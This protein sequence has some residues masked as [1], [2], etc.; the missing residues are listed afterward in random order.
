MVKRSLVKLAEKGL[1]D[2]FLKIVKRLIALEIFDSP[3]MTFGPAVS[4]KF[5][6]VVTKSALV[7]R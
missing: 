5:L 6:N 7:V 3:E 2:G 4:I 1:E